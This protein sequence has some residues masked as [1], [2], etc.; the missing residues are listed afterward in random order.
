MPVGAAEEHAGR[1]DPGQRGELVH[2]R[3]EEGGKAT[4]NRLVDRDDRQS[5]VA[6]EGALKVDADDPQLLRMVFIRL[7][8]RVEQRE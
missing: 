5:A 1:A 3:D 4:I 2:G 7:S 6:R 8:S